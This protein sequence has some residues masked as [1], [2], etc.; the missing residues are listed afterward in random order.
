MKMAES[1]AIP[2]DSL[3]GGTAHRIA[4]LISQAQPVLLVCLGYYAGAWIAKALRFPDSNL[5]LIWPPTAI[6]LGA[7]LLAPP[8]TWWIYLLALAPV[9]VLVQLQDGVSAGGIMS[10]LIGNFSQA[11]LAVFSVRH[12]SKGAVHLNSFRTIVVFT[13]GAIIFAPVV[14]STIAAYL[15]VLSGWEQ[16]YWYAWRARILSNALS[17]LMI[18]PPIILLF[19]RGATT[20]ATS[21]KPQRYIEAGVL[22][23]L[24]V[25]ASSVSFGKE[26]EGLL[27]VAC[28]I[29]LP[30]PVLLWSASRFGLAGLCFSTLLV[31]YFAFASTAA[32]LGFFAMSSPAE[33]VLSVQF[34]LIVTTLPLMLL[35]GLIQEREDK[36]QTLRESE[37][38]YRALVTASAEMVW[39]A[40]AWGEGF[41]VSPSWQQLTGQNENEMRAFGW[42]QAVHPDDRERTRRLWERAMIE[43]RTYENEL[44]VRTRDGS[45]RHFYVHA[46]PILAP[47]GSLHEWV[48]A[49]IDITERKQAE[50]A[51][52]DLVAGTGV[53]G[54]EFFPAYVRHVA[55]ALDV[56]CAT[57]AEV[58]DEQHSRL[59]TLVVW[60]GKGL[61]KNYEYDVADAPCGQVLREG[62]LFCCRERV[63]ERFP[64]CRS[65]GDLNAVSYMGA[66]LFNSAGQLI[67]NLCIIDNKPLDD[68]RRAKSIL[69][70]F[71]ARAAAEIER[72]RA[73]D[74]LRESEERLAR[75]EKSSLVMVTHA[76][77]EGRWLK[78]PPTL[79]ALLGYSEEELL[80]GYSKDATHPDDFEAGWRQCQRLIRGEIKSF[81]LEK[82]Y[83]HRDGHIV[84]AYLNCSMVT[85]S[86]GNPVYFLGY[87][88]DITDRKRVEEALR[89]SEERLRLALEASGMGVWDRDERTNLVKWSKGQ[90]VIMGLDPFSVEP[91]YHT[92]AKCVHPDDLPRA[93]AAMK[94][95]IAER[96]E[97]RSEYR[98]VRADGTIRWLEARGEPI[99]D[100]SGQ[101]VRVMG[102][103]VDVTERKHAEEEI[104]RLKERLEAEN[105]YL[106]TE[107]SGAHRY[108]ELVGRSEGLRRV[109]H[110]IN[111]V[112]ETD[113]TVLVLGETGTGKELVA[114]AVHERSMRRERP[115]V[116]VNCS[117]LPG[118][119]IESELFGH[120]KGAF[121]GATG[122]QVGRF[123]LADGGTIFLDEVGDLPLKLQAKLLRVLQ[124]GEFER[125]GS[126][127]TIKV[128]VRVIAAT[129]RDL[130]QAVQRGRFRVDLYYRLNVYPIGLPPLRERREDIGLLAE[131]FLREASRRLG[132]LFDPISEEVL[133]AL[134][135]YEW[136][137][138]IREMQNVIERAAVVSVGR[139][140]QLPEGWAVSLEPLSNA[141]AAEVRR[142]IESAPRE[143]TLEELERG[144]I[145]QVL[146]QTR[147]R[148]EG[149][150]GA[151]A[152]LGLNPSTLRS[153]MHKLG[154][155]RVD[156]LMKLPVN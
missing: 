120:E 28:P 54:E 65:L 149:P 128:D 43:K 11:L 143:A 95:A 106:R 22:L 36:E 146:Q 127:K 6:L 30:L 32:G 38:R 62:K 86:K 100:D 119:L 58:T 13:L 23:I 83:I 91:S 76:D 60:V 150:K 152:V 81:D 73:E 154:I 153:R 105:V 79:C 141:E 26:V 144:H 25:L 113:M 9:H 107:V 42:L 126:G 148:V 78:V 98:T 142:A 34:Y 114:R 21:V 14:V 118:E 112:A 133:E 27:G 39:R 15:Y 87:I 109:L 67:G 47:D 88:R 35:A 31:A 64:E 7:L 89:D 59:R 18:V 52:Q 41:F 45:H 46:V 101:C 103:L 51:L 71:A 134:G 16:N 72:K 85:D 24:L 10:Q 108:G 92:W 29:I 56:H 90:F 80:G 19:S 70:I 8:R 82:R 75:A 125:L 48:G 40:N 121:T 3:K 2:E 1:L 117:A 12:F 137:G 66:P 130:L 53:I 68:E 20:K 33:N 110:Q 93:E 147:W 131:V 138:N 61:E 96:K 84:W 74:A 44:R 129:N 37:A 5:S 151:A 156:R 123:E 155:R 69:E 102:V 4:D 116:K 111:Q 140:F 132:R 139:R 122:R 104:H 49:N 77:L 55:A 97:Y 135:R 99:Y 63:Q 94:R 50:Q 136:P 57:V 115:L 17:T 124:E 145:L